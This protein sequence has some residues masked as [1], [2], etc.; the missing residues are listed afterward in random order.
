MTVMANKLTI[1]RAF[2]SAVAVGL[3]STPTVGLARAHADAEQVVTLDAFRA[4]RTDAGWDAVGAKLHAWSCLEH[5]WDGDDATA[6]C[7]EAVASAKGTLEEL[8]YFQSP[9]PIA[10]IATDGEIAF[11]WSKGSG[12]ASISFTDDLH[13]IAFLR[14]DPTAPVLRIDEP[15]KANSLRPFFERIGAFA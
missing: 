6:P 7:A 2:M 4:M 9:L 12:F 13:V 15:Y 8:R 1:P 5:G 3:V 11:E 10:T 14:E